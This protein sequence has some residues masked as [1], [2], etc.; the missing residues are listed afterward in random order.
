VLNKEKGTLCESVGNTPY[1]HA[2]RTYTNT[3]MYHH[4]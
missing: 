3:L 1:H 4:N 2:D